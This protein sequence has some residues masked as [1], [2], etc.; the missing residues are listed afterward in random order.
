[1]RQRAPA[2]AAPAACFVALPQPSLRS[3]PSSPLE[4][5]NPGVGSRTRVASA[6]PDEPRTLASIWRGLLSSGLEVCEIHSEGEQTIAVLLERSLEAASDF[7]VDGRHFELFERMLE[8][9]SLKVI[10]AEFGVSPSTAWQR[11][12]RAARAIGLSG[13][14]AATPVLLAQLCYAS[15]L[16]SS[17]AAP[18]RQLGDR[19]F[20]LSVPRVEIELSRHLPPAEV[21][22]CALALDGLSHAQ[23]A[24]RRGTSRRTT[25]NQLASAF[26]RLG[27][28]GR[29]ELLAAV[30]RL[31]IRARLGSPAFNGERE[32]GSGQSVEQGLVH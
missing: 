1:M 5:A 30:A 26:R 23:I 10:S 28:S 9:C 24:E 14:M 12:S 17:V 11:L 21:E 25:A 16:D 7:T 2:G 19:R 32:Y 6:R 29:L 8:G 31:Q 4:I 20:A 15:K 22:V 27:V 3:V 18:T 13:R